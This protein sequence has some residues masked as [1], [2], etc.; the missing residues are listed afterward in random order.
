MDEVLKIEGRHMLNAD[1]DSEED[2]MLDN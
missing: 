2:I 1:K